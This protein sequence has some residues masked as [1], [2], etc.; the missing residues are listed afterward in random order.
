LRN[1]NQRLVVD[2]EETDIESEIEIE[3]TTP[4]PPSPQQPNARSYDA[5]FHPHDPEERIAFSS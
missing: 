5:H 1:K 2:D 3:D 4:H